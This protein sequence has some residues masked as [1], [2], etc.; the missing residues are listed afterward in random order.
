M[1]TRALPSRA[2]VSSTP[3]RDGCRTFVLGAGRCRPVPVFAEE[4]LGGAR[5]GGVSSWRGWSSGLEKGPGRRGGPPLGGGEGQR[6]RRDGPRTVRGV[7]G[8]GAVP[9]VAEVKD[10][11][12]DSALGPR[13][14]GDEHPPR[15]PP[16][17][18]A[19]RRAVPRT[20]PF[21]GESSGWERHTSRGL[22]RDASPYR[23]WAM[24]P[25]KRKRK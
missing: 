9:R 3:G 23:R 20:R 19:Q 21:P 17:E 8:G 6:R 5:P 22:S 4:V 10:T 13:S 12:A 16:V 18:G 1:S 25:G 7:P 14:P 24:H 2:C 15:A 11:G